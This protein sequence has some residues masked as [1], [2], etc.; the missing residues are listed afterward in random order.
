MED[1]SAEKVANILK[2]HG[3]AASSMAAEE[4][5]QSIVGSTSP[6]Q[7]HTDLEKAEKQSTGISEEQVIK[8]LQK[9]TDMF[10]KEVEKINERISNVEKQLD[11]IQNNA[12]PGEV[13][14]TASLTEHMEQAA[15]PEAQQT[16][17]QTPAPAGMPP[18]PTAPSQE[19]TPQ[20]QASA[21]IINASSG[22]QVGEQAAEDKKPKGNH[23]TAPYDSEKY[24]VE[25]F[26]YAGGR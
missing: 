13:L 10:T 1:K 26:F 8:V 15:E 5:A 23:R 17:P 7:R 18:L 24:S 21:P 14:S 4:M 25:K 3:L 2:K 11:K 22:S 6:S 16:L 12:G 9:F 19:P 20:V